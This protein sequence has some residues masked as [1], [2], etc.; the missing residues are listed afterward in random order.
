MTKSALEASKAPIAWLATKSVLKNCLGLLLVAVGVFALTNL[1]IHLTRAQGNIAAI[2]PVNGVVLAL[3]LWRSKQSWPYMLAVLGGIIF[4]ANTLSG[5]ELVLSS[6]L[7]LANV[8]EV[9]LVAQLYVLGRRYSLISQL[10]LL[11][12]FG[13]ATVGCLIS[14]LLAVIGLALIGSNILLHEAI[15][16][17]SADMLGIVLFTPVVKGIVSRSTKFDLF[18]FSRDQVLTFCLACGVAFLVFAQSDYPFLFFVPPALVALAF[19]SGIRGSA[20]GLLATAAIALPFALSDRGPTSL[21]DAS[22]ETKILVLQAFLIVNSVLTFAVAGAVTQ[23]RRLMSHLR[24]SQ[25]RLKRKTLELNEMLGKAR[26]AEVMSKVG[27]WTLDTKTNSVFWSPEVFTIHG[28]DPEEFDPNYNV[29]VG[30]YA[31]EDQKRIDALV[32]EGIATGQG[33]EFEATLIRKSDGEH[34]IVHSMGECQTGPD[35]TVDLV[36]GVFRDI[37]DERRL[38]RDLRRREAHYRLMAEHS[39]DIVLNF[40]LDGTVKFVSPSCRV[41]GINPEDAIGKPAQ[42]FVLPEDREIAAQAVRELISN[43]DESRPTRS[44]HRAPKAGGGYIWLESNPTLIRDENGVPRSVVSSYRD[45][46]ERKLMEQQ[47]AESERQYRMLAEHSTDIVLQTTIGGVIT[48]A[49]PACRKLGVT[50]EQAVGM[51]TLDFVVPE[52]RPAAIAASRMNFAGKEPSSDFRRE[53][54]VQTIDGQIV[55]LEG[56]PNIVR[57]EVGKPVSVINTLRDVTDR[58]ERE[59]MLAAAREEAEAAGRAKAEFLSNMSHE[60]RTP[61]N[62]VLG[63]TQL[64]ART[65][66]DADQKEYLERIQSAGRMLRE[67]V[68]DVLDFSK[69]EAGRFQIEENAFCVRS[70]VED[71]IDLVDAGRKT[72]SV[73][74]RRHIDPLADMSILGDET[75]VRQVLTNL[76]GNAAKFTKQGHIDV[77]AEIRDDKLRITVADTGIGISKD[78]LR[79][80]FEGFRQADSTVS[81]KFGGTGLGLSISRS[82]AELMGGDLSMESEE[83]KGTRVTLTIPVKFSDESETVAPISPAKTKTREA[84]TIVVVDDVEANLS[85]IELGLR[86]TGHHLVTFESARKAIDFIRDEEQ[87]DLVLM[88]IQMPGMDGLSATRAIRAM[89]APDCNVP[90]IALTANAM[91]SQIAEYKAAGMDD[92]FA[93]PIDLDLLESVVE[94]H[95]GASGRLES[96]RSSAQEDEVSESDEWAALRAEYARYLNSLGEQFSEILGSGSQKDVARQVERLA[97][98]IAGTAGSYGFDDI[99]KAAFDLETLARL[100]AD[101]AEADIDIEDGVK[102]FLDLSQGAA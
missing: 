63:F 53:F 14:T 88:D 66:L 56:N 40:D 91:A 39:T 97:H 16:W 98:A 9:F 46:T 33:W 68:D 52:D 81:R 79:H 96:R 102:A 32:A 99:S 27:H 76:I 36:F 69:I 47:M 51:R 92:H 43:T 35:G 101:E 4:L 24:H 54:R 45:I 50:P 57:D 41:L 49:S 23:R 10:G 67:I 12:L 95:L 25:Y 72:K 71:V 85:L 74:I 84:A 73:P 60:I 82:L 5:D 89:A 38:Q 64:I 19:T 61:L 26:L 28:V 37:T 15:I 86:H 29:A 94:Q 2:W 31:P 75:R 70:V 30:F 62:G 48:Y 8:V 80:V 42:N 44:E 11:K 22:M 3:M 90:I 17:L 20:F 13:A 55:W 77:S 58:R 87:V 65:D 18:K 100:A 7:S 93:K 6:F 21:M 59:D 78:S 83:G 34:R 1:S